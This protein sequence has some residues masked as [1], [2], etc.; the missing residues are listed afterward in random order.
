MTPDQQRFAR[1]ALPLVVQVGFSGSR[2]LFHDDPDGRRTALLRKSLREALGTLHSELTLSEQHFSQLA[3]GADAL[4]TQAAGELGWSQRLYLPQGRED[5]LAA[6]G[7]SGPDFTLAERADALALFESPHVI[8]EAVVSTA[9]DREGR[10]DDV[11]LQIVGDCDVLVC[12]RWEGVP[13]RAGGTATLLERSRLRDKPV[14]ELVLSTDAGGLPVLQPQWHGRKDFRKPVLPNAL[15][16]LSP[17]LDLATGAPSSADY[18]ARV[19]THGSVRAS[20]HRK[21][22]AYAA[23]I[24][25][26]THVLATLLAVLAFKVIASPWPLLLIAFELPLLS[27]G[28]YRHVRLHHDRSAIDWALTRLCAEIA[29]SVLAFG[30]IPFALRH[31]HRLPFP[32]ELLPLLRTMNVLHLRSGRSQTMLKWEDVRDDYR[33]KRLADSKAGQ[34][35]YYADK[36]KAA[37]RFRAFA[38]GAFSAFSALAIAAILA[39][40]ALLVFAP[41]APF[42]LTWQAIAGVLGVWLPVL[43][44]GALSLAAAMDLEARS[45]TFKEMHRFLES[46]S[47]HVDRAISLRELAILAAETETR[48]LG[49][50]LNWFAR[51]AFTGVA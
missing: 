48:L 8:E 42:W 5:F 35:A 39:K 2:R 13:G 7:S 14:L 44:V 32:L 30:R 6:S 46:K 11:Q 26:G 50:T 31:L 22:F 17:P 9:L 33:K 36:S 12:L 43:A 29:R 27:Y 23:A 21:D 24:I 45:H 47:R 18:A 25:I 10:F 40:A 28:L 3:A 49:E 37:I 1:A 4:F 41:G 20:Q 51:R 34:V 15:Q 19:K 16:S 38:S